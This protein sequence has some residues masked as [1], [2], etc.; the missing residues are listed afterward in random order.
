MPGANSLCK[1]E[2]THSRIHT[3]LSGVSIAKPLLHI[4][5][6]RKCTLT[7][8]RASV[9]HRYVLYTEGGVSTCMHGART[10]KQSWKLHKHQ[11]NDEFQHDTPFISGL[12]GKAT[13]PAVSLAMEHKSALLSK[14]P[15]WL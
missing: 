12:Q 5:M 3:E 10:N 11:L 9:Y 14:N 6:A 1:Q 2:P 15:G 7:N 13:Q 4:Q 8:K